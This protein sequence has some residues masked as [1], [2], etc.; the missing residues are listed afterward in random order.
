MRYFA[1]RDKLRHLPAVEQCKRAVTEF[2]IELPWRALAARS[3]EQ[4]AVRRDAARLRRVGASATRS[5]GAQVTPVSSFNSRNAAS[6]ADSWS[7]M[8]PRGTSQSSR[9]I[10]W[11]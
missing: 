6:A 9:P 2:V 11:R 4:C 1:R 5:F 8:K 7:S 10:G 3:H